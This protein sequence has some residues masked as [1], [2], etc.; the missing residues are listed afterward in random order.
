MWSCIASCARLRFVSMLNNQMS[1]LAYFS[2]NTFLSRQ[3]S[4]IL[5]D[6]QSFAKNVQADK[7]KC[8]FFLHK[9]K[10]DKKQQCF[11]HRRV[12]YQHNSLF[13]LINMFILFDLCGQVIRGQ[14][15]SNL[16]VFF[17]FLKF[18]LRALPP[19]DSDFSSE[20]QHS[21]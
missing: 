3:I 1:C 14:F 13:D 11:F 10:T 15:H 7:K 16:D 2:F 17:Q 18:R 4:K 8:F 5:V 12:N 19:L 9:S 6:V 20:L 21:P